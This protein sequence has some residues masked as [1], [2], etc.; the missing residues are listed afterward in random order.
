[1]GLIG[2]TGGAS[3]S[4]PFFSDAPAGR[5]TV[6]MTD[7][8]DRKTGSEMSDFAIDFFLSIPC[9]I[10]GCMVLGLKAVALGVEGLE[11]GG[12]WFAEKGGMGDGKELL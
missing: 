12:V 11:T 5:L 4:A 2:G 9:R 6:S 8:V 1:M 3:G 7:V 10:M